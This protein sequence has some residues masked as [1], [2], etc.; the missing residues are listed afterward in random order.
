MRLPAPRWTSSRSS[1]TGTDEMHDLA[2]ARSR[3]DNN[4]FGTCANCGGEIDPRVSERCPPRYDAHGANADRSKHKL[5]VPSTAVSLF[6]IE[7][8]V[9]VRIIRDV[10]RCTQVT[11][12]RHRDE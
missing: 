11:A 6:S 9:P 2:A 7:P 4:T 10:C 8:T 12:R 1:L 3:L 5:C